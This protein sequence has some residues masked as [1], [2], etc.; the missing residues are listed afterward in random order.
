MH[1]REDEFRNY[2]EK[3]KNILGLQAW[4]IDLE[5]VSGDDKELEKA[6]AFACVDRSRMW[7]IAT[8]KIVKPEDY[9]WFLRPEYDPEF[10]IVHELV[11][12]VYPFHPPDGD[13]EKEITLELST[14]KIT[15]A[16]LLL[17]RKKET[18]DAKLS[19]SDN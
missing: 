12:L 17:D 19:R 11:H 18:T 16:L 4:E 5:I 7:E 14:N 10:M 1:E 15:K 13:T 8:I 6:G 2:I 3:W 9:K